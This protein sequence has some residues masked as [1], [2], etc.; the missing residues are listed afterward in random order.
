MTASTPLFPLAPEERWWVVQ[1]RFQNER[2]QYYIWELVWGRDETD[3]ARNYAAD[4]KKLHRT[5]IDHAI[6]HGE[7]THED[8]W[9]PPSVFLAHEQMTQ[10]STVE[11]VEAIDGLLAGMLRE[12][13]GFEIEFSQYGPGVIGG[14][15]EPI[16]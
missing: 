1:S 6:Q 4:L 8:E 11:E 2:W 5:L 15:V 13:E 9:R 16:E 14:G 7:I 3:V 10:V 12:H